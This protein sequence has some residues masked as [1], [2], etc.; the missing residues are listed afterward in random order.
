[1]IKRTLQIIGFTSLL[2]CLAACSSETKNEKVATGD[3]V[4]ASNETPDDLGAS[5]LMAVKNN[6]SKYV[7]AFLPSVAD[8]AEIMNSYEGNE[9][10]KKQILNNSDKNTK[11]I[12]R[13]ALRSIDEIRSKGNKN[14][15]EW[16]EVAFSTSELNTR[17]ENNIEFAKLTIYFNSGSNLYKLEIPECIKSDRGWLIFDKPKWIGK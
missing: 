12:R 16:K 7:E 8:V 5:F 3:P 17:K 1:M 2:A 4:Q 14:G 9:E 15:I 11:D 13:N 10:E 6:D